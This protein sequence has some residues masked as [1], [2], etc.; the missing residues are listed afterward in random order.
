MLFRFGI[1]LDFAL[2]CLNMVHSVK[3]LRE[4]FVEDT[5][6]ASVHTLSSAQ[7]GD[8][9]AAQMQVWI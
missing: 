5:V 7:R 8:D 6:R 3:G 2:N 1:A 9:Y 4:S